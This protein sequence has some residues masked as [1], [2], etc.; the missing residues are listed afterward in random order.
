MTT[1]LERYD[2]QV[3][4]RDIGPE[5][6]QR[7][8][9]STVLLLGCGVSTV[10]FCPPLVVDRQQVDTAVELFD[11]SLAAAVEKNA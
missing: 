9:D 2:R 1:G 6:Q 8:L 4:L 5:G 7:L 3:L 11:Q 10:R